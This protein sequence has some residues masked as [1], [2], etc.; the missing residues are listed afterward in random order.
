MVRRGLT[1]MPWSWTY[2]ATQRMPL[3]HISDSLPSALNMRMR[4]S[5]RSDGQMRIRPSLPTP[6]WRSLMTRLRAAASRG[7]FSWKQS[8]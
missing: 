5:A 1:A 6:K 7:G 3:P 2:L 4:A 8:M